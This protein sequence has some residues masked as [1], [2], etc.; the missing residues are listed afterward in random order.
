MIFSAAAITVKAEERDFPKVT[1]GLE[2]GYVGVFHSGYHY[3]FFAP[4]GY[5]LNPSGNSLTT[6][7]NAEAYVHVGYNVN[8]Y[9]NISFYCGLAGVEKYDWVLPL[10]F[11]GTRFFGDD[12]MK[13]RYFAFID[14][15]SGVVI[16]P[17]PQELL[18]GKFGGGHRFSLGRRVKLD[19]MASIR[20]TYT[21]PQ[22]DYYGVKI[23]QERINRN[24]A[25]VS[26]ISFDIAITF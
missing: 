1:Y 26:A 12:P 16:K 22:I 14:L 4:E 17:D 5:R 18:V 24:N 9:W 3:N 19:L 10:S 6:C 21:H 8:E 23:P 25:Y 15:G 20:T 2:W 11:R 7:S 13:N